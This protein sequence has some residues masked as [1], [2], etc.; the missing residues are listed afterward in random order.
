[1]EMPWSLRVC[2][3]WHYGLLAY[4]S[5]VS[6]VAGTWGL[7]VVNF[8]S[9]SSAIGVN[10]LTVVIKKEYAGLKSGF[11]EQNVR[12]AFA[13]ERRSII[14]GRATP[15]SACFRPERRSSLLLLSSGWSSFLRSPLGR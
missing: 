8:G 7:A 10:V 15:A 11:A 9:S 4:F 14:L 2:R 6:L 12:A 5:W 1:M 13:S 3:H